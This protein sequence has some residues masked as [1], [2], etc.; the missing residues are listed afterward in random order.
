MSTQD[1]DFD[2]SAYPEAMLEREKALELEMCD[3]GAQTFRA[4]VE[5]AQQRGQMSHL[6]PL[7]KLIETLLDPVE[8]ALVAWI[9]GWDDRVASGQRG[10]RPVAYKR[11]KD[12]PSSTAALIAIREVMDRAGDAP[13]QR[14]Q[15]ADIM[16][17]APRRLLAVALAIGTRIHAEARM[18]AWQ[19]S[20]ERLWNSTQRR[21]DRQHATPIHRQRVNTYSFNEAVRED[22]DW[23]DWDRSELLNIGICLVE[24]LVVGTGGRISIVEEDRTINR[25]NKKFKPNLT[26]ALDDKTLETI[27]KAL[28]TEALATRVYMPTVIKP[29]PWTTMFDGGYHLATLRQYRRLVRFKAS[30]E[31]QK[32][33]ALSDLSKAEMPDVY[34]A[35]NTVQEVPWRINKRVYEV[36]QHCWENDLLIGG[37]PSKKLHNVKEELPRPAEADDDPE[38]DRQ[39]RIRASA[40][41]A[42]NARMP[43]HVMK[44]SRTLTVAGKYLEDVF[45]FPHAYDFRGR[46]Y[47]V[48]TDLQPQGQDLA[49]GL[50]TFAEGKPVT[51]EA[52]WW[53]SIQLANTWGMDKVPFGDRHQWVLDN[54]AM[55]LSIALD[56][57]ADRRWSDSPGGEPWQAL[58]ACLEWVRYL[59]NGPGM[60]SSLPI[61]VDGTCNGIQHLSAMVRDAEGGSSV[62]LVPDDHPHDIY[63]EI[64]ELAGDI[65]V[66]LRE[67]NDQPRLSMLASRWLE[68]L[69]GRLPR[70]LTKRPV[71]IFPYGG[72]KDAY[73]KYTLEWMKEF[74]PHHERIPSELRGDMLTLMVQV[75]WDA[76]SAQLRKQSEVQK[77]LQQCAEL[78]AVRGTPLSWT[79]P[80]G[81][82]VRH[83]YG[84]RKERR[85]D[86]L[87]DGQR[88]QLRDWETTA[89]LDVSDQLRG[90]PPNFTH[91]M[92]ASVL[93]T[94]I[95]KAWNCGIDALTCIHDSY[96]T[97]AADMDLLN[98]CLRD[99]FVWTYRQP[100]LEQFRQECLHV[101]DD[102]LV[103]RDAMPAVPSF[104]ALD[105]EEVLDSEYFFA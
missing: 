50:L 58:A 57:L 105:I 103:T 47:P 68:A 65:L 89:D 35:I 5:R 20:N 81:F 3:A 28:A 84:K 75:L 97:V 85:I 78:A 51:E 88:V 40:L 100:I 93:Q 54:E 9:K 43:S 25:R 6:K 101:L 94:T 71:M 1:D 24:Q 67:E 17:P 82:V 42:A 66:M 102:D 48:P 7:R 73:R 87:I 16:T 39:W 79:T 64:A 83:F 31:E 29:R 59:E 61:R 63:M 11:L 86:T 33:Y 74:D 77:W 90:I 15:N 69:G 53:L 37:M 99:S 36:A 104:G 46:M 26:V 76:V 92:D 10:M 98:A 49:R 19:Q 56:P 38:I 23:V 18:L 12:F 8:Q 62:N 41:H 44:A 27:T 80:S 96:G 30:N 32:R 60:M 52:A 70:G 14:V 34:D 4:T 55:F 91:S 72:T 22:I 45:Y 95:N 13:A 21:L 2:Y